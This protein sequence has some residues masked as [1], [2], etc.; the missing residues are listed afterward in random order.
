VIRSSVTCLSV[1]GCSGHPMLVHTMKTL[2][3]KRYVTAVR[4]EDGTRIKLAGHRA[5]TPENEALFEQHH[6]GAA[7]IYRD[8]RDNLLQLI[9]RSLLDYPGDKFSRPRTHPTA[10]AYNDLVK[11]S[12]G[13][14]GDRPLVEFYVDGIGAREVLDR[15][16]QVTEWRHS[17]RVLPV[18]F[19][20]LVDLYG[21][22]GKQRETIRAIADFVGASPSELLVEEL[23]SDCDAWLRKKAY[24]KK[25]Y[26]KGWQE[27][28]TDEDRAAFKAAFGRLLVDLG[29]EQD[30]DW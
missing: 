28:F 12:E 17:P 6:V 9:R 13:R 2:N 10:L 8:P 27:V 4:A 15:I 19:E 25:D 14:R 26:L 29:Y 11:R 30:D 23:A 20:D 5:Y 7:L 1:V 21:D 24:K 3:R 16:F 18:R 22:A